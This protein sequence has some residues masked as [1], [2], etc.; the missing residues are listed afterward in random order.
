MVL[1]RASAHASSP[2]HSTE[3]MRRKS[4]QGKKHRDK[5]MNDLFG[6][7]GDGAAEGPPLIRL[8]YVTPELLCIR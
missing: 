6:R 1:K 2:L 4:W 5:V 3:L 8:L 7:L